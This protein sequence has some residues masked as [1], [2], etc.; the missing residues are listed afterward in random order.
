MAKDLRCHFRP[1]GLTRDGAGLAE[2]AWRLRATRNSSRH[3]LGCGF[4]EEVTRM[5]APRRVPMRL[6]VLAWILLVVFTGD[7]LAQR[8]GETLVLR[9]G[10]NLQAAIDRALPGDTIELE[11]GATYVGN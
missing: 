1:S 2:A 3:R 4:K 5:A 9:A 8:S 11:S 7:A 6:P 10:D